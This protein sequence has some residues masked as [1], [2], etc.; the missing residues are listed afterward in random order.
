M[1]VYPRHI[2][3][4]NKDSNSLTQHGGLSGISKIGIRRD[5]SYRINIGKGLGITIKGKKRYS[6]YNYQTGSVFNKVCAKEV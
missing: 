5:P 4:R 1:Q 3:K 6:S 2:R